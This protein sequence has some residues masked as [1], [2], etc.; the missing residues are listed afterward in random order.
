[1]LDWNTLSEREISLL[2]GRAVYKWEMKWEEESCYVWMKDL[3]PDQENWIFCSPYVP[4]ESIETAID[5]MEEA[6]G[7]S[8]SWG[9]IKGKEVY[10]ISIYEEL[11][12]VVTVSADTIPDG[13]CKAVLLF[14][15]VAIAGENPRRRLG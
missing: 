2:V 9:L 11:V 4:S 12:P 1:M 6:I 8:G 14:K 13:I 10:I 7:G 15:G 5:T 3:E